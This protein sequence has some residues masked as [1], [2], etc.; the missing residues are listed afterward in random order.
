[1]SSSGQADLKYSI[2]T[3]RETYWSSW[4]FNFW[5]LVPWSIRSGSFRITRT[6]LLHSLQVL[7]GFNHLWWTSAT[8]QIIVNLTTIIFGLNLG[9]GFL[10]NAWVVHWL[11]KWVFLRRTI[12]Q[13]HHSSPMSRSMRLFLGASA[14]SWV[15]NFRYQDML[16]LVCSQLTAAT[17]FGNLTCTTSSC[18]GAFLNR[19]G[20]AFLFL[21]PALMVL[22]GFPRLSLSIFDTQSWCSLWSGAKILVRDVTAS[23]R[24]WVCGSR[25]EGRNGAGKGSKPLAAAKSNDKSPGS[26]VCGVRR[27]EL[28]LPPI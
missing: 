27:L 23:E 11:I 9:S 10:C 14:R 15:D 19:R 4:T 8:F 3:D 28:K 7:S 21:L 1:M 26:H 25:K 18:L 5:Q 13:S 16:F 17:S 6:C 22:N 12:F 24:R 2:S 20:R